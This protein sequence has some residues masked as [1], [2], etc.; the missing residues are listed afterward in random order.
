MMTHSFPLHSCQYLAVTT[1]DSLPPTPGWLGHHVNV[2]WHSL[3][4]SEARESCQSWQP[5]GMGVDLIYVGVLTKRCT[6]CGER[7]PPV[8]LFTV[9]SSAWKDEHHLPAGRVH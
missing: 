8:G 6:C 2:R 4:V 5:A 9:L 7:H 1:A 3:S